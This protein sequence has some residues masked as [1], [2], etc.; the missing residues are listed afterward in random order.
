M[1]DREDRRLWYGNTWRAHWRPTTDY[2]GNR[3]DS[4]LIVID[5]LDM[6]STINE[7]VKVLG[8]RI[9]SSEKWL[10]KINV[11]RWKHN[12]VK[13]TRLECEAVNAIYLR[14]VDLFYRRHSN[15]ESFGQI[16]G[17]GRL[18]DHARACIGMLPSKAVVGKSRLLNLHIA[19][20]LSPMCKISP[21]ENEKA[22]SI[23]SRV[24]GKVKAAT[25]VKVA[26]GG[27]ALFVQSKDFGIFH[28]LF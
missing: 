17:K 12:D 23:I 11:S 7:V 22:K 8:G 3:Q 2:I 13:W 1:V 9:T 25:L 14:D 27:G 6:P 21:V 26:C 20:P 5:H 4:S 16:I 15:P 19:Q 18:S 24:V 10:G 28:L